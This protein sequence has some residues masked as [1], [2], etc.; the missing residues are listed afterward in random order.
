MPIVHFLLR[1][2]CFMYC[3]RSENEVSVT[4]C[5]SGV[6][7]WACKFY[8]SEKEFTQQPDPKCLW[9]F[10]STSENY[11][12]KEMSLKCFLTFTS[13]CT[14]SKI[15][16]KKQ[17]LSAVWPFLTAVTIITLRKVIMKSHFSS[18][19]S[20]FLYK[21]INKST[22]SKN[23]NTNQS[24]FLYWPTSTSLYIKLCTVK[25][26]FCIHIC[27]IRIY[28]TISFTKSFHLGAFL[29]LDFDPQ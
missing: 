18:Q 24:F 15:F 20:F 11:L 2:I 16:V 4:Y 5:H 28:T 8:Y 13:L 17:H 22:F 29:V 1:Q 3:F 27:N 14:L 19:F 9:S 12:L 7:D 23:L 6:K 21:W 26:S 10:I 25:C